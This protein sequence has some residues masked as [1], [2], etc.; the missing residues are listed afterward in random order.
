MPDA[1]IITA[2]YDPLRDE[3]MDY[4]R[5]L[6]HANVEVTEKL[7]PKV[8]HGFFQFGGVLEEGKAVIASIA[9]YI[10]YKLND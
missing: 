4:A 2:E 1:F 9:K 8:I 6:R 3:G 5:K 7:Y 10:R